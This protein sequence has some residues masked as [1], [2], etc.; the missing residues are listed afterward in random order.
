MRDALKAERERIKALKEAEPEPQDDPGALLAVDYSN[1][2]G[3]D[4]IKGTEI[5]LPKFMRATIYSYLD[6]WTLLTKVAVLSKIERNM[7]PEVQG[8]ILDQ[9]KTLIHKYRFSSIMDKFEKSGYYWLSVMDN[10]DL[11][12]E[13]F[14]YTYKFLRVFLFNEQIRHKLNFAFCYAQRVYI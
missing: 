13:E 9:D 5:K 14:D 2:N 12:I 6:Y 10:F 8:G 4:Y 7:L 11:L 3:F 1:Y